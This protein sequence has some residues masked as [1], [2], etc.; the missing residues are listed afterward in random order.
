M[1]MS[2]LYHKIRGPVERLD[3]CKS[4]KLYN[5]CWTSRRC[6]TRIPGS[7]LSHSSSCRSK[8]SASVVRTRYECISRVDNS[9]RVDREVPKHGPVTPSVIVE[10]R[11]HRNK[12]FTP[13]H[14]FVRRLTLLLYFST[15]IFWDVSSFIQEWVTVRDRI[16]TMDIL[17]TITY[18]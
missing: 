18:T 10:V 9:V 13:W 12:D 2:G 15:Y 17:I 4:T 5:F 8:M 11:R 3:Q 14:L 1:L 7:I 6:K 16:I